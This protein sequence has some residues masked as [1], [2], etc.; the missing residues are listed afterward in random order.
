VTDIE[1]IETA[2]KN[3]RTAIDCLENEDGIRA[4]LFDKYEELCKRYIIMKNV[5]SDLDIK[6]NV[7]QQEKDRCSNRC[8]CVFLLC[9]SISSKGE[10]FYGDSLLR[11]TSVTG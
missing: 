9:K 8:K 6:K 3:V 1:I 4:E 10:S 5:L 11:A 7:L 2:K